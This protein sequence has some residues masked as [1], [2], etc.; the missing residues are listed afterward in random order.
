[1]PK[2]AILN[3]HP[4]QY[5]APLYRRLAQEPDIDLMVY[6]C[7][8]QGAN[9]YLDTGF[10]KRIK[11]DVSLLDGYQHRFLRN[12]RRR[13]VVVLNQFWCLVNPGIIS[14]LRDGGYDALWVN[15]HNHAT[16]MLAMVAARMLRIPVLMRCETQLL[17]H[18]SGIKRAIREPVL[19]LLYNKLCR[20]CLP[21]GRLNREFYQ[22]HGVSD[23]RLFTVPYAVDNDYF[24]NPP[25]R[26]E[27]RAAVRKELGLPLDKALV[28]FVS[29][30]LPGKRP[31]DL[32][33]AFHRNQ[34]LGAKAAVVFVGSGEQETALNRYVQDNG[35]RD[36][37]FLGFRNQSE[38][39]KIYSIADIFV[40]PSDEEPWGLV[41][42]EVMC[43]GLPVIVSNAIGAAPDLVRHGDNGFIYDAGDVGQLSE[44]LRQLLAEPETR[45]RMGES[46]RRIIER[47]DY[48]ACVRG[49]K[50]ALA[51][52]SR[53]Q[54]AEVRGQSEPPAVAGGPGLETEAKG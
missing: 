36:V 49:V 3:T 14:E 27:D 51:A 48:E 40:F 19:N 54:R 1:M 46:S 25:R 22:F 52:V 44:Y 53:G 17:L 50:E 6:F 31:M 13:D 5:F 47:W 20:A 4:I 45:R 32:L 28:L 10:G 21:I 39:P 41:L 26:P 33:V 30:L 8:R 23:D 12:L 15:G 43:A 38:L 9:E 42:N 2:L 7:S 37:F 35:L 29:K 18:R 16:Y 34:Q 24:T 11:W